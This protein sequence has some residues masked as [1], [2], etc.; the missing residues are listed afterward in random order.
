MDFIDK[1]KYA[2]PDEI[3]YEDLYELVPADLWKRDT[4]KAIFL[5][6]DRVDIFDKERYLSKYC[7]VRNSK[8]DPI[9]HYI[10][11][12]IDEKRKFILKQSCKIKAIVK[13]NNNHK[14][15]IS[16]ILPVFNS[17]KFLLYAL[18]SIQKQSFKNYEVICVNDASTDGSLNILKNYANNDNRFKIIDC[19]KN[20]G[21]GGARN[22]ALDKS[23]GRYITFLDS[24]DTLDQYCLEKLYLKADET[25][26][27][28]IIY[29]TSII[30]KINNTKKVAKKSLREDLLPNKEVFKASDCKKYIFNISYGGLGGKCLKKDFIKNHNIRFQKSSRSEDFVFYYHALILAKKITTIKESLYNNDITINTES[31]ESTK[32]E[33]PTIFFKMIKLSKKIIEELS[34]Y[35]IYKQSF[36]NSCI[37]RIYYNIIRT[38][39]SKSYNLYKVKEMFI[40][41]DLNSEILD[42][43]EYKRHDNAFYF[44]KEYDKIIDFIFYPAVHTDNKSI[45]DCINN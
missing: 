13:N 5:A 3:N 1:F 40:N 20:L 9:K 38:A 22:V 30:D 36:I 35:T 39:K 12:G 11:K 25:D 44:A 19:K 34:N 29:K 4:R 26:A 2:L 27:D 41:T 33:D 14:P 23:Q 32:N 43:I 10:E 15:K 45:I 42:L 16:V 28:I 24:D 8:I 6:L 37:E 17:E 31:L 21:A 7:D 18:E